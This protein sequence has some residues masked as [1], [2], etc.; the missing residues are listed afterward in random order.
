MPGPARLPGLDPAADYRV[1]VVD[2]GGEPF[3]MQHA[4]TRL[5]AGRGAA[6]P[7]LPGSFLDLVGLPMPVLGPEQAVVLHLTRA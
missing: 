7:V 2:T 1:E 3:T 5:V 6:G 4:G